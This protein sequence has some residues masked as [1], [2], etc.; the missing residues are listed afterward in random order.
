[1][2]LSDMSSAVCLAYMLS[3]PL[4]YKPPEVVKQSERAHI[5]CWAKLPEFSCESHHI[6]TV[7]IGQC[8]CKVEYVNVC[9]T[10]L[11][12]CNAEKNVHN[13]ISQNLNLKIRNHTLKPIYRYIQ[14][15][16][17]IQLSHPL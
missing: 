15:D 2:G 16:L 17:R 1:M 4:A 10:V 6:I 5:Q 11:K 14:R 12:S 9:V 3:S 8:V 7:L 13:T